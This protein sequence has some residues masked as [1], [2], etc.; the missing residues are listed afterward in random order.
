MQKAKPSFVTIILSH[1]YFR[2]NRKTS[3][4]SAHLLYFIYVLPTTIKYC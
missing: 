1:A 4:F 3:I 2:V